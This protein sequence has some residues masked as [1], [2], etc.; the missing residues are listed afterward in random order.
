MLVMVVGGQ[1][2]KLVIDP[3][4]KQYGHAPKN[5]RIQ[6]RVSPEYQI[7]VVEL[8]DNTIWTNLLPGVSA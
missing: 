7:M 5:T 8:Q 3:F 6:H 2:P 4:S 1:E